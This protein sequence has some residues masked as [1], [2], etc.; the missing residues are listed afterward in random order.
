MAAWISSDMWRALSC[1][2]VL[3]DL[4]PFHRLCRRL[5][6]LFAGQVRTD[7]RAI[8]DHYG[9]DTAFSCPFWIDPVLL[10]S[11]V[12]AGRRAAADGATA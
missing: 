1:R 2:D 9:H 5:T 7:T 12:R 3:R 8:A 10:A 4:H 6:P 11:A